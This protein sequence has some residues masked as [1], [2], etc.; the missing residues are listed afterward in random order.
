MIMNKRFKT[1]LGGLLSAC[2]FGIALAVSASGQVKTTT[3]ETLGR[4]THHVTVESGEIVFVN[5]NSVVVKMENG[6]LRHFDNVP[7]S[8]TFM[9]SGV[10]VNIRN[11]KVGMKLQKQTIITTQPRVVTAVETVNGTVWHVSLP[12]TVT[13][14]LE[15]GQNQRFTIPK[16]QKFIVDGRETDASGLRKG[17]KVQVQRVT[18]VSETVIAKETRR[19]GTMPPPPPVPNPDIPILVVVSAPAPAPT[20]TASAESIPARLP[21]TASELSLIGL[22][23]VLLCGISLATIVA[24]KVGWRSRPPQANF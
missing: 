12:T 19:T 2:V 14:T 9:V 8:T 13:L 6:E 17:M 11:A 7:N 21:H 5:G 20:V 22:L 10:P 16:G 18:E 23:G 24:R 1:C 4:A 15:N 3:S